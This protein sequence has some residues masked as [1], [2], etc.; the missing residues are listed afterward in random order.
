MLSKP[1]TGTE[2]LESYARHKEYCEQVDKE[3]RLSVQPYL[4][5]LA[6]KLLERLNEIYPDKAAN[7]GNQAS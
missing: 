1:I 6:R 3:I 7:H 4:D 5:L 2:I